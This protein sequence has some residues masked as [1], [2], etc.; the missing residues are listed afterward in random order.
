MGKL[1]S[2]FAAAA[3]AALMNL[4]ATS[5]WA[6][7]ATLPLVDPDYRAAAPHLSLSITSDK[8][9]QDFQNPED[10]A[11]KANPKLEILDIGGME[12][13]IFRPRVS[14]GKAM[15]VVYYCHGGGYLLRRAYYAAGYQRLADTY[16]AAI[17]LP[18]YR[19]SMEAPFPAQLEDAARGLRHIYLHGTELSLDS[20]RIA[21][22]G[23]SAGGGLAA[24][25]ALWNRDHDAIPLAAQ[26]LVYPMLDFRT[27]TKDDRFK[28]RD[29][30]EILW[31]RPTNAF[32][33]CKLK[34]GQQLSKEELGYFSPSYAADLHSLPPALI[35]VG[36]LDLFVN[37]DIEYANRLIA[38]GVTTELHV[39]PG[40][41]HGFDAANHKARKTAD[42]IGTVKR[43]LSKAF[44]QE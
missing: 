8:D 20:S 6:D 35:Y 32:A 41:Y 5:A 33:W 9:M 29:T 12:L 15:P 11:R 27:G 16:G 7:P 39:I 38:S 17:V 2:A 40:L 23:D 18:S 22:M 4:A 44:A 36:T 30:G 42:F 43:A 31:N 24:S 1:K 28:A 3:A 14:E 13:R 26:I 37:E 25:L 19:T 10:K 34:G 21:V